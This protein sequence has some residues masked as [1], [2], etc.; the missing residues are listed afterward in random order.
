M[1]KPSKPNLISTI[2]III[3][4]TYCR[5]WINTKKS[6][7][8]KCLSLKKKKNWHFASKTSCGAPHYY[9]LLQFHLVFVLPKGQFIYISMQRCLKRLRLFVFDD[10]RTTTTTKKPGFDFPTDLPV[11]VMVPNT[12]GF[13]TVTMLA[14][15]QAEHPPPPFPGSWEFNTLRTKSH[16]PFLSNFHTPAL[17]YHP[18]MAA[19]MAPWKLKNFFHHPLFPSLPGVS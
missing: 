17:R 2:Y 7:V 1:F 13:G 16:F 18:P 5:R 12:Q 4:T 8:P 3:V 15:T 19:G 10:W 11:W 9:E 6:T 14:Q